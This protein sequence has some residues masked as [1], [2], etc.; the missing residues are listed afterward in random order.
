M[1]Q[2]ALDQSDCII[3]KLTISVEQNDEKARDFLHFD[4]D[5]WKLK[6]DWKILAWVWSEMGVASL[7][8]GH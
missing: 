7:V 4:A 5:S 6:V 2:N 1:G 8:Q 3:F